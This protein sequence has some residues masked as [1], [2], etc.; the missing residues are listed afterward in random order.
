MEVEVGGDQGL[1][2]VVESG[3]EDGSDVGRLGEDLAAD[4]D[5]CDVGGRDVGGDVLVD[6][7]G[8]GRREASYS[9]DLLVGYADHDLD[10]GV[11]EGFEHVAVGVVETD[12]CDLAGFEECDDV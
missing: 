4:G 11:G 7:G 6:P 8:C 12:V 2:D 10:G 9:E 5:G 1:V 3:C